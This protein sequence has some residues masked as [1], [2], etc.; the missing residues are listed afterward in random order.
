MKQRSC[1]RLP[2]VRIAEINYAPVDPPAGSPYA[3][4]EFEWVEVVNAGAGTV[5]LNGFEISGGINY[6]FGNQSL[7]AGQES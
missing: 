6:L 7:N 2:P 5:N 3:A 4:G 1:C